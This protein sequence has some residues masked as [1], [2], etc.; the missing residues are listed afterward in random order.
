MGTGFTV[1][2]TLGEEYE[3]NRP[4]P[5]LLSS[6]VIC[7]SRDSASLS[8][9]TEGFG[10]GE[11]KRGEEVEGGGLKME[12]EYEGEVVVGAALTG[13]GGELKIEL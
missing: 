13:G 6:A 8:A 4:A 2:A 9:E 1:L 11:A 10:G 5:K 12:G 3:L 7:A